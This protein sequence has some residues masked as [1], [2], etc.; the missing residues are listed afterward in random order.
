MIIN[1]QM[2]SQIHLPWFYSDPTR[3]TSHSK[4]LIGNKFS[5]FISHEI[6][7]GNITATISDNLPNLHLFL[8]FCQILLSNNLTFMKEISQTLNKKILYL[9][10]LIKI[11]LTYFKLINKMLILYGF[12]FKQYELHLG[13]TCSIKKVNKCKLKFKTKPWITFALQKYISKSNSLKKS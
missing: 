6:V 9:T 8:S 12:L 7:S 1:Q 10:V 13:Y 4:A 11:A 5:N 2:I 3:I